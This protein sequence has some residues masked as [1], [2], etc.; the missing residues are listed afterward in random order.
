MIMNTPN[1]LPLL[2]SANSLTLEYQLYRII[3]QRSQACAT[4]IKKSFGRKAAENNAENFGWSI[5][6]ESERHCTEY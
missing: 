5:T 2:L 3:I 1:P 4:F 6:F